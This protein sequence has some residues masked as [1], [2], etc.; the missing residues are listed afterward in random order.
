ML[1]QTPSAFRGLVALAASGDSR[2][3]QLAVRA[4]VF[5]GEKLEFAD[6]GPWVA[7]R[8]LSRT[9]LVNMYGITE[10]TVHSSYYATRRADLD[11]R[12]GNPVGEPLTDLRIYLLDPD[13]RPV[14]IGVPG[15]IHIGGPGVTRGY[16]NRPD[17]TAARFVP[18]PFGPAG[19][20]LYRSGDLAHRT[21]DGGLHFDGRI[22]DQVKIRGFRIEL[23][24]IQLALGALPGVAEAVVVVRESTPG[25]KRLVAYLVARA[26]VRLPPE[27]LRI[28]L[29]RSLPEYM[30]PAAFVALPML[31]L[32]NNGKLDK[33]ALP[34]PG[35]ADMSAGG[36]YLPPRTDLE[37]QVAQIWRDVLEVPTVGIRDSFFDLGGDSIRAVALGGALPG[38][39][40]RRQRP[41]PVFLPHHRRTR[42]PADR[43]SHRADRNRRAIRADQP[44]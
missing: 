27:Q 14:P 28:E 24:E 41:R 31:P 33:R 11:G 30:I 12:T 3:D 20:R 23:A 6:L 42:R 29:A 32:T 7:R 37:R 36:N 18:D 21:A 19:G 17:L 26:G 25:D 40:I 9:R 16:L 15:E 8:D 38:G 44:R 35:R 13:G 2:V 1:N 22:D 4:V 10:T 39:R 34:A 43:C 5:A